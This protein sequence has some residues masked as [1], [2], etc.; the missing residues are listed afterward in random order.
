MAC[1]PSSPTAPKVK[2]EHKY[3]RVVGIIDAPCDS[4][5]IKIAAEYGKTC[6]SNL[7]NIKKLKYKN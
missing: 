5:A 2:N 4:A 3:K 1:E 7:E 6:V